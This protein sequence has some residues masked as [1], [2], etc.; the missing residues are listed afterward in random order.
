MPLPLTNV[1]TYDALGYRAVVVF[2][3]ACMPAK[4]SKHR[5][6]VSGINE[7]RLWIMKK[8]LRE[9]RRTRMRRCATNSGKTQP[10]FKRRENALVAGRW[11]ARQAADEAPWLGAGGGGGHYIPKWQR[12]RSDSVLLRRNRQHL[13]KTPEYVQHNSGSANLWPKR[14][15][16]HSLRFTLVLLLFNSTISRSSSCKVSR[17]FSMLAP[18]RTPHFCC[19]C[20]RIKLENSL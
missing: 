8:C 2:T 13:T 12:N 6:L 18:R 20:H 1:G 19:S 14:V 11:K 15:I 5:H 16:N 9:K 7:A 4:L 3:G 10:N 17:A